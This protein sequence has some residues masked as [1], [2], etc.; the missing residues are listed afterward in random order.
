M[1]VATKDRDIFVEQIIISSELGNGENG[2]YGARK[3]RFFI[4]ELR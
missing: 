4:W 1:Y 3:L 2:K